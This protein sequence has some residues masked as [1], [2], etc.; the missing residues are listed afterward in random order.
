MLAQI[1]SDHLQKFRIP[2]IGGV[3]EVCW[4]DMKERPLL[5]HSHL[6]RQQWQ[7]DD[8]VTWSMFTLFSFRDP[9]LYAAPNQTFFFF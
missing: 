4:V 7:H 6:S 9:V 1:S 2:T 5:P 8:E 3:K